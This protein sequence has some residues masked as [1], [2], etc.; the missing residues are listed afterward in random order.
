MKKFFERLIKNAMQD[1]CS[2]VAG[3]VA[4]A[5]DLITGIAT[6]NTGQIVKGGALIFLGLITKSND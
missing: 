1:L 6:H 3:C 5:D 4:G 2:S